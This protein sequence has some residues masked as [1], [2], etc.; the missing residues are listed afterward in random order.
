MELQ[1]SMWVWYKCIYLE[2]PDKCKLEWSYDPNKNLLTDTQIWSRTS[3]ML[4]HVV[5]W[6]SVSSA[7]SYGIEHCMG[8]CESG[9][10]WQ[11]KGQ[12][13]LKSSRSRAHCCSAVEHTELHGG[14]TPPCTLHCGTNSAH[15][16]CCR[17]LKHCNSISTWPK[18]M[19]WIYKKMQCIK[20]YKQD[21][22]CSYVHCTDEANK[23]HLSDQQWRAICWGRRW[24]YSSDLGTSPP[25]WAHK[26]KL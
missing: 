4:S 2:H 10:R 23:Q 8:S 5:K 3:I 18:R 24:D 26:M 17:G 21:T 9:S 16:S 13:R 12:L 20:H 6:V 11:L 22:E 19:R 1:H 7:V 14:S 15:T 25:E